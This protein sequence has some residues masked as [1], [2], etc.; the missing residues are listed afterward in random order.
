MLLNTRSLRLAALLALL[1][2]AF[3][4][5]GPCLVAQTAAGLQIQ[6]YA[7]LTITGVVGS[8]YQIQY[9]TDFA[10][11]TNAGAWR[12]L[13]FLKLPASPFLWV[14][15]SAPAATRRFYQAL[16][17]SA[18]SNMVFI[19]PGAFRM[20]SPTNEVDRDMDEG[21]RTEVTISRG[22]WMR[23]FL[24]TQGEYL[25][26]TG[27]NPSFFTP[28]HGFSLDLTRPV[29]SAAWYDAVDFCAE[30]TRQERLA[31]RIPNN[32][33]YRLP[34]E[35]EWEYACRAWTSTRFSYG[36]D[37]G[38]T[39]LANFGWYYANSGEMTHPVGEKAPNLL[40][41]YDMQGNLEEWCQDWYG[42]Y[43]GGSAVDPPGP[44]T[45]SLRVLRG[46]YWDDNGRYCRA[47][48]RN[49][50]APD[51]T[52]YHIGFRLVLAPIQP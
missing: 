31:G 38:Y 21:P 44:A 35:A 40:G 9:I 22:F 13:E 46:G 6:T 3:W 49:N 12:C 8:V 1:C 27:N 4:A 30:F 24:V 51:A 34:T 45:G 5:S 16:A 10:Q 41:L 33:A 28:N 17:F 37:P 26:L 11:S 18:P 14:D 20:G 15:T 19:P 43:V 23:K 39:N 52:H 36:D 7:G 48:F 47:A 32:C 50:H 29:D 42:P 25:A 2:A